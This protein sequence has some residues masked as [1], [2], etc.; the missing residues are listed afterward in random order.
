MAKNIIT[1]EELVFKS[2]TEAGAILGINKGIIS[3]VLNGRRNQTHN[4]K[5]Y[6][7]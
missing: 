4:Y 6:F 2:V 3:K 5:F 7:I 1:N